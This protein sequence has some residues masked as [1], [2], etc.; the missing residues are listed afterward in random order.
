MFSFKSLPIVIL[1]LF[2]SRSW[3]ILSNWRVSPRVADPHHLDADPDP[4][5]HFNADPVHFNSDPDPNPDPHQRMRNLRPLV[6][7]PS[8]AQLWAS[9]ALN[10]R[11]CFEPLKLLNIDFTADPDSACIY[12][13]DLDPQ[14]WRG[15]IVQTLVP[16]AGAD[17]VPVPRRAHHRSH[18]HR[19]PSCSEGAFGFSLGSATLTISDPIPD[20][21]ELGKIEIRF[22]LFLKLFIIDYSALFLNDLLG[23]T[24][25]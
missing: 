23:S 4:S 1:P 3:N 2:W 16:G 7:R 11:L 14:P 24:G 6:Y 20:P 17:Q 19:H 5:F 15:V 9:M 21:I 18:R 13:A 25:M 10:P 12:Y 8:R 22:D